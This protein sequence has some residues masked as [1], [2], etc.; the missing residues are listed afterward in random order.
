MAVWR[1]GRVFEIG[2]GLARSVDD[3]EWALERGL[4][5]QS[6]A[7]VVDEVI[8]RRGTE[9]VLAGFGIG[10]RK[11]KSRLASLPAV[12]EI[13]E[14]RVNGESLSSL[15]EHDGRSVRWH[16]ARPAK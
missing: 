15:R 2:S 7:L 3:W 10:A 12:F 5:E 16:V 6:V 9:E 11:M 8:D 4:L 1:D 13:R 14:E